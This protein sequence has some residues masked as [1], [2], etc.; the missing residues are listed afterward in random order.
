MVK[1]GLL[2]DVIICGILIKEDGRVAM[3]WLVR[4]VLVDVGREIA[5]VASVSELNLNVTTMNLLELPK[6]CGI[7]HRLKLVVCDGIVN[8][9]KELAELLRAMVR[10]G[11]IL[12]E[13]VL[14]RGVGSVTNLAIIVEDE[15]SDRDVHKLI[16]V[17]F[18]L[19]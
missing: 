17:H 8:A 11:P 1:I 14:A 4:G 18:D 16:G 19:E 7:I 9:C 2:I 15:D 12:V 10:I 5:L 13:V 6:V 3:H